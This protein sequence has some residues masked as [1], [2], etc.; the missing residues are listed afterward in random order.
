MDFNQT[1]QTVAERTRTENYEGGEAF[2]PDSPERYLYTVTSSNLLEDTFYREDT[3]ALREIIQAVDAVSEENPEFV[4]KLA[5]FARHEMYLRQVPQLLLVLAATKY[6][7]ELSDDEVSLIKEYGQ[8]VID[9]AD[10]P[11]QV[12]AIWEHFRDDPTYTA[13]QSDTLPTGLKKAIGYAMKD[14]DAYQLA[15]YD[16]DRREKNLKDAIN[17][18]RP[19]PADDQQA[20]LYQKVM[21]GELDEGEAFEEHWDYGVS[22]EANREDIEPLEPPET[23]EVVISERGNTREA[24]EDVLE[25]MALMARLRNLRNMLEAGVSEETIL[26]TPIRGKDYETGELFTIDEDGM[27]M[28]GVRNSYIFPFRYYT[29]YLMLERERGLRAPQIAE[30]LEDAVNVGTEGLEDLY[31]DSVVAVDVSSSMRHRLSDDSVVEYMDI[32]A[33]FG[34]IFGHKGAETYGFASEY[35]R[36]DAHPSTPAIE[37][38]RKFYEYRWGEATYGHKFMAH[39]ADE[40]IARDRVVLLSDGQL[41]QTVRS[42]GGSFRDEWHRYKRDVAP[43]ASLYVIDLSSYGDLVMPE[44]EPDVYQISGWD[45]NVL[46]FMKYGEN[47]DAAIQEIENVE[48]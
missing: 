22:H 32:A 9:R 39:L 5:Q 44:G 43:E 38:A 48:P 35:E 42:R 25:R 36:V 21:Q 46:N 27:S 19:V 29:A 47:P 26:N 16:T 13:Q 4:L 15:K 40:E 31:G 30:W 33:L 20:L 18:A 28:D 11:A 14:F 10:E 1:K 34:G 2:Q 7:E 6:S 45:D 17:M 3:E 24:W 41:Y 37:Y 8:N 12:L 23:W